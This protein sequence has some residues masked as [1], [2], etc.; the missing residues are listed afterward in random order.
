MRSYTINGIRLRDGFRNSPE[1]DFVSSSSSENEDE[2]AVDQ[3]LTESVMG[4]KRR[5]K[6]RKWKPT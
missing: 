1:F 5:A 3:T 6:D 2:A 4:S